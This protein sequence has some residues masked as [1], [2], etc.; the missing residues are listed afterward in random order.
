MVVKERGLRG[1]A[2]SILPPPQPAVA[3]TQ[4]ASLRGARLCLS[5]TPEEQGP[6]RSHGDHQADTQK[7][8]VLLALSL[9]RFAF[10]AILGELP[11]P[12]PG[13]GVGLGSTGQWCRARPT[14]ARSQLH[15]LEP[16]VPQK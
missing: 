6:P 5:A 12:S 9:A 4:L 7:C 15:H 1:Q 3:L 8:P 13:W 16:C 14:G 11:F 10:T 2:G